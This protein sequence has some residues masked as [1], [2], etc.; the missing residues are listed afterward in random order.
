M[1]GSRAYERFS[2]AQISKICRLKPTAYKNTEVITNVKF[3]VV[4]D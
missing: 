2:A 3:F 1:T 4:E